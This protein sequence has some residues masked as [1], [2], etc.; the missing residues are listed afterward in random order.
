MPAGR[1]FKDAGFDSL[2]A[3]E[4]R[5]R[6]TA[7]T[8]LRLTPTLVFDHPTPQALA[9]HI[10]GALPGA[11]SAV[12]AL[13]GELTQA[14]DR[15]DTL[16]DRARQTVTEQLRRLLTRLDEGGDATAPAGT[17]PPTDAAEATGD[18]T[19]LLRS[20]S[21]DELFELLDSGFRAV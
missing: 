18:V 9:A 14:V 15:S 16:D 21:D 20:A 17:E 4:L 13:L 11:D 5:N 1:S 2:T 8:G 3:V 7:E 12:L 19:E 10:D 6:L